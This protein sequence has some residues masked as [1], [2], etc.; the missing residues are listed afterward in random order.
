MYRWYI[1]KLGMSGVIFA[2]NDNENEIRVEVK[3]Y[4]ND[5]FSD[6]NMTCGIMDIAL[7]KIENDD[8][9]N[10]CFPT[11]IATNY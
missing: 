9:Y 5:T 1:S 8:D 2:R 11:T 7:W 3:N 4:V 10:E 6:S